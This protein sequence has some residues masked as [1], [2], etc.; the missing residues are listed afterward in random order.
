MSHVDIRGADSQ[1][2]RRKGKALGAG[3][4][5]LVPNEH[6][7]P[8]WLKQNEWWGRGQ[9]TTSDTPLLEKQTKSHY[10]IDTHILKKAVKTT[11]YE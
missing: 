8:A 9:Q 4:D 7:A 1:G 6:G 11:D 5:W 3:V 2:R 10:T